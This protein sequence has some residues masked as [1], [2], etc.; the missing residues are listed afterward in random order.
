M[1]YVNENVYEIKI[2]IVDRDEIVQKF[3][4]DFSSGNFLLSRGF[5]SGLLSD[6]INKIVVT[7]NFDINSVVL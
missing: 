2:I 6:F 3:L 1:F 4:N 7:F 5:R